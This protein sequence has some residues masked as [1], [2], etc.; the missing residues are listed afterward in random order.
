[1]RS[2]LVDVPNSSEITSVMAIAIM[3][4]TSATPRCRARLL[5]A[6]EMLALRLPPSVRSRSSQPLIA[7]RIYIV[8]VGL[9]DS[10]LREVQDLLHPDPG[11]G[12]DLVFLVVGPLGGQRDPDPTGQISLLAVDLCGVP[13]ALPL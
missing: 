3:T 7:W 6:G 13:R 2:L 5:R 4:A 11:L 10:L 12:H 8:V 9:V 1:M